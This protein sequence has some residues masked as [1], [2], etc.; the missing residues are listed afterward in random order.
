MATAMGM[1]M[2]DPKLPPTSPAG[3]H[4]CDPAG[5]LIRK[6]AHEPHTMHARAHC[7][8]C[9]VPQLGGGVTVWPDSGFCL[10]GAENGSERSPVLGSCT[11]EIQGIIV[12]P[13]FSNSETG[14]D[15]PRKVLI[16]SLLGTGA[17]VT[18]LS[19]VCCLSNM[20]FNGKH[21]RKDHYQNYYRGP[22]PLRG[23]HDD[24]YIVVCINRT[25][26]IF[27]RAFFSPLQGQNARDFFRAFSS[28]L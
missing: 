25:L 18:T 19:T 1:H 8:S 7:H 13:H 26:E 23:L 9:P 28:L 27:L 11:S 24:G 3:D 12:S 15:E 2:H 6:H 10:E 5:G 20:D 16:H 4:T 14:G 21:Y 17:G 22:S